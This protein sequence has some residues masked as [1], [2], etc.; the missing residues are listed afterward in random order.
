M[1]KKA[2]MWHFRIVLVT[3]VFLSLMQDS[4]IFGVIKNT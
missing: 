4:N 1:N 3:K 2:V